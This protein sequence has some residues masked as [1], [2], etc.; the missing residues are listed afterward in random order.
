MA[1]RRRPTTRGTSRPALRSRG[2]APRTGL[3]RRS[4]GAAGRRRSGA[5][6]RRPRGTGSITWSWKQPSPAGRHGNA[7]AQS[8]GD[9]CR[10]CRTP[11]SCWR[12]RGCRCSGCRRIATAGLVAT[13]GLG[14]TRS[15]TRPST[16]TSRWRCSR[17]CAGRRSRGRPARSAPPPSAST[18][19]RRSGATSPWPPG[20]ACGSYTPS[21]GPTSGRMRSGSPTASPVT[22]GRRTLVGCRKSYSATLTHNT[23]INPVVRVRV[24]R[25]R[26]LSHRPTARRFREP[27]GGERSAAPSAREC[28]DGCSRA[29]RFARD[30]AHARPKRAC[31]FFLG[32]PNADPATASTDPGRPRTPP[33]AARSALKW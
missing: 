23:G 24:N 10:T 2:P 15:R 9:R 17:R 1:R 26:F 33:A 13:A 27:R 25:L 7:C 19:R 30:P 32:R 22:T 4:S 18:R 29:P 5:W 14:A 8:F 20:T 21:S 16:R 31:V 11:C 28:T 6:R 12:G 3:R